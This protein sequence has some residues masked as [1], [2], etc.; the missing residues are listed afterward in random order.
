MID[1]NP[2][3]ENSAVEVIVLEGM[4]GD[5]N[6]NVDLGASNY[7]I[8]DPGGIDTLTLENTKIENLEYSIKDGRHYIRDK[9]TKNVV[10]FEDTGYAERERNIYKAEDLFQTAYTNNKNDIEKSIETYFNTS[11]NPG[12]LQ[13]QI[14]NLYVIAYNK[15]DPKTLLPHYIKNINNIFNIVINIANSLDDSNI[16]QL[17]SELKTLFNE[18]ASQLDELAQQAINHNNVIEEIA[19]GGKKYAAKDFLVS[20]ALNKS[21]TTPGDDISKLVDMTNVRILKND[22]FDYTEKELKNLNVEQCNTDTIIEYI[23]EFKDL[24]QPLGIQE[25]PF[26]HAPDFSPNPVQIQ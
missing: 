12:Q 9:Q 16:S 22:T 2:A 26:Y 19:I 14:K 25:L 1:K 10:T 23:A 18:F 6:F 7:V 24:G 11:I 13:R 20:T 21:K 17:F 4:S 5:N 3:T 8:R 15:T